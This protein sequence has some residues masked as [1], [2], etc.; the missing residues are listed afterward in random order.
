MAAWIEMERAGNHAGDEI[1]LRRR[2]HV[3]EILY[4]DIE[5]MSNR[6]HQSE[7][8]L[9]ARS[10]RLHGEGARNVLV[11]GLGMGFTLRTVLEILDPDA[12]VTVCELIPE[13]VAWNYDRIGHLAGHPLSDPRVEVWVGDIMDVLSARRGSYDVILMDTDNGPER[14]VRSSNTAI[15]ARDG[16]R[17]IQRAL[18]PSG[19]ASFWSAVASPAFE[20]NLE[21]LLWDWR[22]D[23][24]LLHGGRTDA[25]H[26][27]YVTR[28]YPCSRG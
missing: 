22:R 21:E 15:Y 14:I 1:T 2:E 23:D 17:A 19:I 26:Y 25:F 12:Q 16:L 27:I 7:D 20:S 4:N 10:L 3:Y 18:R 11:G 6:H 28:P 13:V 5:L 24:I 8:A 9:A